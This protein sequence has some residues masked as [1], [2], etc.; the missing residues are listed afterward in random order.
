MTHEELERRKHHLGASDMAAVLGISPFATA[1]DVWAEKT[2]RI[3][4]KAET[5][6]MRLGKR[7]EP[8]ILDEAEERLGI[9][10]RNVWLTKKS[11]GSPLASTLDARLVAGG[12][13]VEAKRCRSSEAWGEAGTDEIPD[14]YN[15]QVQVQMLC[16][17]TDLAHL[18]ALLDGET[19]VFY[20]IPRSDEIIK[21]IVDRAFEF[22]NKNVI[23]GEPPAESAPSEE[24]FKKL[25][26]EPASIVPVDEAGA[27][28]VAE[29]NAARDEQLLAE[30]REK[31][32]AEPIRA[33][34]GTSEALQLPDGGR[35]TYLEQ[36]GAPVTDVKGLREA[37]PE[38]AAK[39][40]RENSF[41]VLRLKKAK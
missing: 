36:R 35:V 28:A 34:F 32:A 8:A 15:V 1:Y 37:H 23:G 38:I 21:I 7:F 13:P 24:T 16:S 20:R 22:W 31:E 29:W 12:F 18:V 9:L 2:G 30:K 3:E 11:S 39:Y 25:R 27:A 26:R 14:Y 5:E 19:F 40:V 4:G 10:E 6:A 33:L 41:R 17:E